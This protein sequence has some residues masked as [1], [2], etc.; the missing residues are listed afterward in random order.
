MSCVH[1]CII[2]FLF[3]IL[4]F[5]FFKDV[6]VTSSSTLNAIKKHLKTSGG[7]V[8]SE[9]I[10]SP[11]KNIIGWLLMQFVPKT[12]IMM[13]CLGMRSSQWSRRFLVLLLCSGKESLCLCDVLTGL[14][15]GGRA[16]K[17]QKWPL[18]GV[19]RPLQGNCIGMLYIKNV[20]HQHANHNLPSPAFS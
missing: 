19:R 13:E 12:W 11:H 9:L 16:I 14:K 20:W 3:P 18:R 2:L 8:S 17:A 15:K 6:N 4:P 5:F 1:F 7:Q 10:L